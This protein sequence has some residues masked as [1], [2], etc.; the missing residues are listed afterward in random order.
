MRVQARVHHWDSQCLISFASA[1]RSPHHV[2][3]DYNGGLLRAQG[4]KTT[5]HLGQK[6]KQAL[7]KNK[8]GILA[9]TLHVHL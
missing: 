2:G 7:C 5:T 4:L 9:S 8:K 6:D 3:E 1:S